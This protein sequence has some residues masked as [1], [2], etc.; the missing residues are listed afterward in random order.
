MEDRRAA[1]LVV[2]HLGALAVCALLGALG[3]ANLVG[4]HAARSSASLGLP[5]F[6]AYWAWTVRTA[7]AS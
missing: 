4:G 1:V 2:I 5:L 7:N 3:V 6:L